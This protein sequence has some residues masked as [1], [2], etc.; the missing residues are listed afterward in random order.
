MFLYAMWL[1]APLE[2][3]IIKKALAEIFH[4][5]LVDVFSI[6]DDDVLASDSTVTYTQESLDTAKDFGVELC[7]F[8]RISPILNTGVYNDLILALRLSNTLKQSILIDDQTSTPYGYFLIDKNKLF[9]VDEGID[10][11]LLG[12]NIIWSSK[13]ELSVKKVLSCLPDR[14][15]VV[16]YNSNCVDRMDDKPKKWERFFFI[17]SDCS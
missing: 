17:H 6:Y 15:F 12:G 1:K 4:I 11:D 5:S 14:N 3:G 9:W 2:P 10:D 8:P 16:K 13:K 7:V